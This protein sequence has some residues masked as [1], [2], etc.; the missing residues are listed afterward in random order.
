MSVADLAQSERM[1]LCD[2]M[3]ELGPEAP[4]LCEGWNV[5]DL[6]AHLVVREH[7]LWAAPGIVLGGVFRKAVE[8]AMHRR[9]RQG[10]ERLVGII[11]NGSPRIYSLLPAGAQLSEYFI[12]HEDV[13]RANGMGPRTGHDELDE[14]LARLIRAAAARFLSRVDSGVDV[15]WNGGVLYRHGPEPRAVL[16]GQ[17]G[18]LLLYLSGRRD[19]ADVELSGDHAAI[20]ALENAKLGV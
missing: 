14:A 4:T 3:L 9:R 19:A 8:R 10:L 13:R 1:G 6:A 17:P 18:E 5:L 7:D 11:R 20:V 2:L 15:V 16:S 12:H